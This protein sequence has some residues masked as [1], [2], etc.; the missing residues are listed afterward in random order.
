[1]NKKFILLVIGLV[2]TA[3]TLAACGSQPSAET[4]FPTGK[5]VLPNSQSEG[6]YFNK[7]GTWSG[8]FGDQTV[9]EGTYQVKDDLYTEDAGPKACPTSATYRY[10]FDGT[11]LKFELV[12]EDDCH[13]RRASFDGITYV[14]SK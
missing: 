2:L 3:L 5:F 9:A 14:L 4:S 1:M 7:D 13:N 8:F 11:N 10:T 12:G 6:I